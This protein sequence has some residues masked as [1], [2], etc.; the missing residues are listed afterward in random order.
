MH[1]EYLLFSV[2]TKMNFEN[3]GLQLVNELDV[4]YD[5]S[6]LFLVKISNLKDL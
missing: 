2:D 4:V 5:E 1:G 6:N 3:C